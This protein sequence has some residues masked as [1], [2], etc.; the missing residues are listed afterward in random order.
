MM[1]FEALKGLPHLILPYFSYQACLEG[2][3]TYQK[4]PNSHIVET[5][6]ILQLVHKH[7]VGP[8]RIK[9]LG[10]AR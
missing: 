8:F 1:D 2:K 4:I 9:S 5:S 10:G 3:Q 6:D 7:I